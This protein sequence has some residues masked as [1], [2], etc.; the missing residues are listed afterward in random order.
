MTN[1]TLD[2]RD[3]EMDRDDGM[4]NSSKGIVT[5][6]PLFAMTAFGAH[7]NAITLNNFSDNNYDTI[8]INSEHQQAPKMEISEG[9]EIPESNTGLTELLSQ[10]VEQRTQEDFDVLEEF[11]EEILEHSEQQPGELKSLM[12]DNIDELLI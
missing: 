1:A 11:I 4:T 2:Q 7:A 5:L 10:D 8:S 12:Y 9:I 6:L 3:I